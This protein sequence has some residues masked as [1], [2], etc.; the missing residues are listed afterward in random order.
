MSRFLPSAMATVPFVAGI[1]TKGD[2]RAKNPPQLD[3]CTDVEFDDLGGLRTRHPYAAFSNSIVGGG[4]ISNARRLVAY[5]DELLLFT[6]DTLYSW[7]AQLAKW[8]SRGTHLAVKVTERNTF[9]TGNEQEDVDRAEL[10]NT[11]VQTW[12]EGT[13]VYVAAWDR[14]T[15]SVALSPTA[16]SSTGVPSRPRLVALS[17]KILLFFR[18][19]GTGGTTQGLNVR[20]LDPADLATGVASSPTV[21]AASTATTLCY[22][23]TRVLGADQAVCALI[24]NPTTSYTVATVTAGLVVATSTKI[25]VADGPIAVSS[26]PSGTHVQVARTSGANVQGD[27]IA[28]SGLADVYTAQAIGTLGG[29]AGTCD[30]ITA[31]HRSVADS[32]QYRCYAF[33]SSSRSTNGAN[34]WVSESNYVD[35]GNN[36]G[37]AATFLRR[38]DVGSRAF[39]HDGRVF[40]WMIHGTGVGA[41]GAQGQLQNAS[42]LYRDDAFLC[43][44]SAAYRGGGFL[45]AG[46]LPGVASVA[47]GTYAYCG[48]E[49]TI[50]GSI[51]GYMGAGLRPRDV[52]FQFD[53]NE[54]R[55]TARIGRTLYIACGEGVLQYDG[56][57]ITECGFHTYPWYLA[58]TQPAVGGVEDGEYGYKAS[59]KSDNAQAERDRSASIYI[60]TIDVTGGPKRVDVAGIVPLYVTHK[61][62]ASCEVWRTLKDP[63]ADAPYYLASASNPS[64]LANPNRYIPND[65]TAAA[66]PTMQDNIADASMPE[67]GAHPQ[68][69]TL[70]SLCAPC[71]SII[72]ATDTRVFIAGVGGEPDNVWYSKPRNDDEVVAFHGTLRA[73]V[74]APGG[75]ITALGWLNETLVVFRET[76]IYAMPGDGFDQTGGGQNL[77]PARMISLDVG[78]VNHESVVQVPDGLLFK[79][80]KGWYLLSRGWGVQYVGAPVAAYDDEEPLAAHTMESQHQ[81]RILTSERMLVW[82]Y[83]VNQWGEWTVDDGVD[84]AVWGGVHCYL[85]STG[86]KEQQSTYEDV[87]YGWDVETAWIKINELQGRGIVRAVALLG[88]YRAAHSVRIRIARNYEGDGSGGW[89]YYHDETEGIPTTTV[90]GQEQL[91]IA[92]SIK[93]PIQSLKVRLT[94]MHADRESAPEGDTA[95]LTGLSLDVAVEPG[96]YS[97]LAAAQKV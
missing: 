38:M 16:L 78:A 22:D 92:P 18:L 13:T 30:Q 93:R 72:M 7:N 43:A 10:N 84:A 32:G 39:D 8:V 27:Y 67:R 95:R 31:A 76:A 66:L 28:I 45:T 35:T 15:K 51:A 37:T 12:R 57:R 87:D 47:S 5:G 41:S 68:D 19:D 1:M 14:T 11:I 6:K 34:S 62:T 71:S 26:H 20:A 9:V 17:T 82:D 40:V 53:T 63:L 94:A 65:T 25:R 85:T 64:A 4:T 49:R 91:K 3:I 96:L 75:D 2:K 89:N 21:V 77:G 55:R 36:L 29:G 86:P 44:K 60:E 79:S 50:F 61:T 52:V 80:S 69:V 24:L 23:V 83:L 54:A 42:F 59:Y 73:S 33:W 48:S 46:L 90:G 81:V 58:L 56:L 97:G 70:P 74:P 88:E